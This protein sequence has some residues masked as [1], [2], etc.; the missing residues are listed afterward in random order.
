MSAKQMYADKCFGLPVDQ[1]K[2]YDE[3]TPEQLEQ[4]YYHFGRHQQANQGYIYAIKKDGNLVVMRE[5]KRPE[6]EYA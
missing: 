6:W 3:L 2:N 5:R 4:V 1:I